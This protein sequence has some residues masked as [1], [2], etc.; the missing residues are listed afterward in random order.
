MT[1]DV[2]CPLSDTLDKPNKI[3]YS[4]DILGSGLLPDMP[5]EDIL[6]I[7]RSTIL[8]T[9]DDLTLE[10]RNPELNDQYVFQCYRILRYSRGDTLIA[11]RDPNWF[12]TKVANWAFTGLTRQNRDDI[13]NFVRA[14]AG[15]YISVTDYFSQQYQA[16]IMNPD[17][18]ITQ[19]LPDYMIRGEQQDL[20]TFGCGYTWK[21]DLQRKLV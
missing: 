16:I 9:Y 20:G 19:E 1:T 3:T 12:K 13:I 6:V 2:M 15:K 5:A 11:Y 10:L 18:S 17:N 7:N 14:S 8:L 4:P 21:V